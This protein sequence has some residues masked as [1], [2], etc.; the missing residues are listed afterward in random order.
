MGKFCYKLD[1]GEGAVMQV[2]FKFWFQNKA[3]LNEKVLSH[4]EQRRKEV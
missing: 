4:I 2:Q 3:N 1:K